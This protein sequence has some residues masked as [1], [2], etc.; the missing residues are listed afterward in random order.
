MS[1]KRDVSRFK[2]GQ[3]AEA[4]AGHDTGKVYVI[5]DV[6]G[7]RLYLADGKRKTVKEPKVKNICH[8]R[9]MNYIDPVIEAKIDQQI[10]LDDE[11]VQ[12][13]VVKFEKRFD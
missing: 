4:T 6:Q 1:K 12:E 2:I 5:I 7:E 10:S 9:R 8:V 13:A 11:T 3:M